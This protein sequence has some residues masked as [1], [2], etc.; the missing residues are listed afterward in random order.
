MELPAEASGVPHCFARWRTRA[1]ILVPSQ[2]AH[3]GWVRL[4]K[5]LPWV[6]A[7]GLVFGVVTG[8]LQPAIAERR[9]REK[10]AP[11]GYIGT[12]E[13]SVLEA[14]ASG[15][16]EAAIVAPYDAAQLAAFA[17]RLDLRARLRADSRRLQEAFAHSER[18]MALGT[19]VAG[20]GH[21]INN[22]LSAVI[23]SIDVA[24]RCI[25]PALE[26]ARAIGAA[27]SAGAPAPPDALATIT[28][29]GQ[30]DHEGRIF[31]DMATAADA[32]A[33]I[34]RDLSTFAR[35][36]Q[37]EAP[38]RVAID[39]LI[40]R[41][42]RLSG[43]EA[44]RRGV[45]ER[46]YA[47]NL[48]PVV[49]PRGRV[50][51]V[52]MNVFIN[53]FHA[54]AEVDRPK[55]RVKIGARADEDFVAITVSDTGPGIPPESLERIFDPFF[56]TKRQGLGTGLGL[57]ISRAILRRLGGELSVESVYGEGATFVCFLPI[58]AP[59]VLARSTSTALMP[60][61][62]GESSVARSILV[63]DDDERILR[64]YARLLG[65]RH[66]VMVAYDGRE[67]ID[68]IR[69]GSSPEVLVIELDLPSDENHEL[70][71]WLRTERPDLVRR[72]ILVT[73]GGDA[74]TS[75]DALRAHPGPILL[76]PMHGDALLA[77]I[78]AAAAPDGAGAAR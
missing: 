49:L 76:K 21:E 22:P 7:R 4:A 72:A 58:P 29:H 28:K 17:D 13:P 75:A 55:H 14:L 41:A 47:P 50:T 11:I 77:A 27:A 53:A 38:E 26:A 63:V 44:T 74:G 52:I 54:I 56:T 19:L 31:D 45:L 24:R 42:I 18:L 32:I 39:E 23:L 20:V 9:D 34:V 16:D 69:S 15:A 64:S 5:T 68:L 70:L 60:T 43:R 61:A 36:D 67:A 35:A 46:D 57:S 12:D 2:K 30:A 62:S 73:S 40:E 37:D 8:E 71:A 1:V 48:P 78:D 3:E 59:D 6:R 10:E 25:L 66:R 51:Q 33:S 65:A